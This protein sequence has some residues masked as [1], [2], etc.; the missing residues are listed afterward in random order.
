VRDL[1]GTHLSDMLDEQLQASQADPSMI[2]FEITESAVM[3]DPA[4]TVEALNRIADAGFRLAI[5]DFGTGYSSFAYLKKLPVH[6]LKIDKS[7]VFGMAQDDNDTAIVRTSIELAHSLNLKV[8]AEGVEDDATLERLQV[9]GCD[10][11]QGHYISRPLPA[12]E[13]LVWL[14]QSSWGLGDDAA[15]HSSAA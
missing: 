6:T 15:S 2:E 9:L 1:Q 7:F 14:R 10:A 11:V 12:G 8:V 13:L 5:D 4:H 3:T